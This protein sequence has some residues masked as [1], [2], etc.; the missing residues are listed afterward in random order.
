MAL[1]TDQTLVKN[2]WGIH[3]DKLEDIIQNSVTETNPHHYM[4][5][6]MIIMKTSK[7]R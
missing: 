7:L 3:G 6:C 5:H 1:T 2:M 4:Y